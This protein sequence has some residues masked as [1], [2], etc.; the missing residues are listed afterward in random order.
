MK[1][2][3]AVFVSLRVSSMLG[4]I[5]ALAQHFTEESQQ[6]GSESSPPSVVD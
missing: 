3:R 2:G 4:K 5:S 1:Q 6:N